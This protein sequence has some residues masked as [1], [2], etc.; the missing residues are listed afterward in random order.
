MLAPSVYVI[1]ISLHDWDFLLPG[2]PF[3]GLQNYI[4]LFKPGTVT[5]GPFWQ[6]MEA[7]GKFVLFSVP[8]L[9]VIP[10]A[11]AVMLNQKFPGRN[12]FRASFFAP[13]VLGVAVVGILWRFLLD[14]NIGLVN[15]LLDRIGIDANVPWTT[16]TPWVWAA[17]VGPTVWWTLG[18]NTVIYL[19]GLQD[20]PR[21][22]YEAAKVDGA[23]RWQQ[24]RNVTIPGLRPVL[25]FVITITILASANVF[26]Q[27]YLITQG[28]P[29]FETRSAIMYIGQE[30]LREFR[31]GNAAAMSF[32]LTLALM[33]ISVANF[34]FFRE[35]KER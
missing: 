29:G 5:S 26:G 8:L 1:W 28:R 17:L 2:K 24:F 6:S 11:V 12:F 32:L 16:Q 30:G 13:Y 34:V 9:V 35:R 23:N 20:I 18:F 10:L 31:M 3:V 21:E 27:P 14:P 19:A 22:L 33:L 25:V 7:T 15:H 4:N